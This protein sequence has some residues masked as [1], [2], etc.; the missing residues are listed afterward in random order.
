V[1]KVT[2]HFTA[3]LLKR[4]LE[5]L[6]RRDLRKE[7]RQISLACSMFD[8]CIILHSSAYY[9][10]RTFSADNHSLDLPAQSLMYEPFP[11]T[12]IRIH[13]PFPQTIIS[14]SDQAAT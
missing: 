7:R 10:T 11:Q 5:K 2:L 4:L 13:E 1:T 8:V 3:R 12:I 14:G 9:N 6:S